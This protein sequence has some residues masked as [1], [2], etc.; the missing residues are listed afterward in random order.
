M[1]QVSP[2]I[3]VNKDKC[4]NCHACITACPVK[5]CNDGSG[6]TVSLNHDLCIGCG[7]CLEACT[8]NARTIVDDTDEFLQAL[9]HG[10]QMVAIVAPSAAANFP[11]EY[12]RLNGWLKNQG[13]KAVFDVSFGA[14]LTIKSYVEHIKQNNPEAVISQPCPAIVNYIEMYKPELLK[15]LAPADS[16]MLHTAKMIKEFYPQYNNHKVAVIS[17][18]VAKKR[19]F[20]ETGV[21]DYNVTYLSLEDYFKNNNVNLRTYD[22][23]DFDNPPAERAVLFSTPGGLMRTAERDVPGITESTRKI[24]GR[25]NIY[26]YLD[27]LPDMIKQGKAPLLIDCLNCA[28]GCNGGTG[29]SCKDKSPDEV[30]SL[31]EERNKQMQALYEKKGIIKKGAQP[32]Q[33]K[34]RKTIDSKWKPHIYDRSYVDRSS[35]NYLSEPT[36]ADIDRIYKE[37]G[38]ENED[39]ILN[40]GS[41]GYGSCEKMAK[42]IH[43]GL[44]KKE[45]CM[46]Y[47]ESMVRKEK[48]IA[49]EA[50]E[51]TTQLANTV[52][53]TIGRS[54]ESVVQKATHLLEVAEGQ[55]KEFNNLIK[56]VQ[57]IKEV[58]N[59]FD[60]IVDAITK[61]TKQTELLALNAA[62][63][64]ARAGES[65]RGFSVVAE[66]VKKLSKTSQ[67]ETDKIKP[68]A[69]EIKDAFDMV[70]KKVSNSA[71]T[72]SKTAELT[73]EVTAIT[74]EISAETEKLENEAEKY[75]STYS[76]GS[77]MKERSN[78]Y[79]SKEESQQEISS[80]K[81]D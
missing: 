44:N 13:V 24:E 43:N 75:T 33:K 79:V 34:L 20:E 30:E 52:A 5:N 2:V 53:S 65:G 41:C 62:I 39:D 28:L 25:E 15:Y 70:V 77:G 56:E 81:Q 7:A 46:Q 3:N 26:P 42:A 76:N 58:T 67:D 23:I 1:S 11:G 60:P 49:S 64:A 6:D 72:F 12:L 74:E 17:P 9:K 55:R 40:C 32:D 45:N 50:S 78:K 31:V 38:K 27:K 29:T 16:P 8:H 22:E 61:V 68:Y 51:Q 63:E 10:E 36:Q 66:E 37:M 35:N 57:E 18:C 47:R 14:E 19:E 80:D 71:E 73:Q 4:V 59:K 69:E 48:E 21:G 54:N